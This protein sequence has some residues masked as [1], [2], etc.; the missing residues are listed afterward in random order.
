MTGTAAYKF[1]ALF[2][3]RAMLAQLDPWD[4]ET[5]R[6]ASD[7]VRKLLE[8]LPKP[9][10]MEDLQPIG[11]PWQE[12]WLRGDPL[13]DA[14]AATLQALARR[15]GEPGPAALANALYEEHYL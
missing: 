4:V 7:L 11:D 12:S 2:G 15:D 1:Q 3:P 6:A 9:P 10:G 14:S 13:R 8:A 5:I